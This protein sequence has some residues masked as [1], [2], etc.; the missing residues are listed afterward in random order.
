MKLLLSHNVM[1]A[2]SIILV[3][4]NNSNIVLKYKNSKL[5]PD[6]EFTNHL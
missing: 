6:E 1:V 5:K 3:I 4:R 2:F